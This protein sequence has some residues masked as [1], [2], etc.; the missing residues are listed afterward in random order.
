MRLA[1]SFFPELASNNVALVFVDAGDGTA[2]VPLPA[3][4]GQAE[5]LYA[6]QR[7]D[8]EY[9]T[10]REFARRW[11]DGLLLDGYTITG[12]IA[13]GAAELAM[14]N[15]VL[16]YYRAPPP[17]AGAEVSWCSTDF[18]DVWLWHAL[19]EQHRFVQDFESAGATDNY[20]ATLAS[21]A[22]SQTRANAE[23]GALR[24]STR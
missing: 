17:I 24:M 21:D 13:R 3:D 4:F 18:P 12:G 16:T 10:A 2:S 1:R 23:G 8:L 5:T 9:L 7:G 15:T 19:A 6:G 20:A 22:A 14:L 11:A